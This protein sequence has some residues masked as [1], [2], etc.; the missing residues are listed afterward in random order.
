MKYSN[1]SSEDGAADFIN[2][3]L[4]TNTTTAPLLLKDMVK[5]RAAIAYVKGQ[6]GLLMAI[7]INGTHTI[8]GYCFKY[9]F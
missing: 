6:T 3:T 8:G 7:K 9:N 2:S 4:L 1:K 5:I